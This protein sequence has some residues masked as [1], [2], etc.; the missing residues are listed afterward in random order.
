MF[1]LLRLLVC[2][3]IALKNFFHSNILK[4]LF[5]LKSRW[6]HTARH[7]CYWYSSHT[8]LA[9]SLQVSRLGDISE[10]KCMWRVWSSRCFCE[11]PA[12][13]VGTFIE[14]VLLDGGT[15]KGC[16]LWKF[17]IKLCHLNLNSNL[18]KIRLLLVVHR[19]T[20]LCDTMT[21]G[22]D[23]LEGRG[24]KEGRKEG[25]QHKPPQRERERSHE[26]RGGRRRR[27]LQ[28]HTAGADG[29]GR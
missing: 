19:A 17:P 7:V 24:G 20:V 3:S 21:G 27:G 29:A 28:L 14:K 8:R 23:I 1:V 15:K 2:F 18:K 5:F 9:L 25:R 26:E 6:S 11:E 22:T 12:V 16:C 10:N 4:I 13:R